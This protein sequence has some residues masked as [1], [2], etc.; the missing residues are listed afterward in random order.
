MAPITS[1]GAFG[2]RRTLVKQKS[3]AMAEDC[4]AW[5][6]PE[7]LLYRLPLPHAPRSLIQPFNL[8][9]THRYE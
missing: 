8:G 6:G 7:T 9:W 1:A 4:V 2:W 3:Y 5:D